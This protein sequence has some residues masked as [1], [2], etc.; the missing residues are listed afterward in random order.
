MSTLSSATQ[1]A[2]PST[3]ALLRHRRGDLQS[4]GAERAFL[5]RGHAG[6]RGETRQAAEDVCADRAH[7]ALGC[8]HW[9]AAL[10]L[11]GASAGGDTARSGGLLPEIRGDHPEVR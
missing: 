6:A 11:R 2:S 10:L 9:P 1:R 3:T 4:E 8:A 7:E 5:E